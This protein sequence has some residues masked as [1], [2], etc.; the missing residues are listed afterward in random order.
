MCTR[1]VVWLCPSLSES[2]A[3]LYDMNQVA[4]AGITPARKGPRPR[5]SA[6]VP[7]RARMSRRACSAR[8]PK[9]RRATAAESDCSRVLTTS[10]GH[11]THALTPAPSLWQGALASPRHR[12]PARVHLPASDK[13]QARMHI[14][15]CGHG[16]SSRRELT[17]AAPFLSGSRSLARCECSG[18]LNLHKPQRNTQ[19]RHHGRHRRCVPSCLRL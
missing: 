3:I 11:V 17:V 2:F 6:R 5:H 15:L 16:A 7:S 12:H 1:G 9:G 8:V 10:S 14:A 4:R 13:V 18:P 19:A